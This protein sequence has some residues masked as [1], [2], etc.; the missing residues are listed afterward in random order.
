MAR[1]ES[2]SSSKS[3][4]ES[5]VDSET[6]WHDSVDSDEKLSP[7]I[8]EK[9]VK[10]ADQFKVIGNEFFKARDYKSALTEYNNALKN[11][12]NY[13]SDKIAIYYG[14]I[15]AC[16]FFLGDYKE[17]VEAC[18]KALDLDRWHTKARLRR[19][20][21]NEKLNTWSSLE[22]A[23]E[24]LE[25]LLKDD[26]TTDKKVSL[27]ED[28][29][30]DINIRLQRLKPQLEQKRKEEA[31]E[32]ISKFKTMGNDFLKNFGISLDN[33]NVKQNNEGGYTADFKQ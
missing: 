29:R 21:A 14:N 12:P 11:C 33:I 8:E 30:K 18:T 25:L 3:D 16:H 24:D 10:E 27:G 31:E 17:A 13:L 2:E 32:L 6:V 26:E 5:D 7:E 22:S 15:S 4:S 28:G 1:P 19:A 23:I 9:L 20:S